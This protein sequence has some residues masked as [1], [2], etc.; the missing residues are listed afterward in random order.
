VFNI[1]TKIKLQKLSTFF[2]LKFRLRENEK[3]HFHPSP[4]L[5]AREVG[6]RVWKMVKSYLITTQKLLFLVANKS[7]DLFYCL[8]K[9]E[10]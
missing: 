4:G 10:N 1:F 2:S 7:L 9:V 3:R 5:L 8:P 6:A